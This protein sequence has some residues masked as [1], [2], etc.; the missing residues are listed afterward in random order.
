MKYFYEYFPCSLSTT[1]P[2]MSTRSVV[3][4]FFWQ[5]LVDSQHLCPDIVLWVNF[6]WRHV[7][8]YQIYIVIS[9]DYISK[10]PI[11]YLS[12][13]SVLIEPD[14]PRTRGRVNPFTKLN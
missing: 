9:I 3:P 13:L 4:S 2:L 8:S 1:P 5:H 10:A 12:S 14:I 6:K 7:L 11:L